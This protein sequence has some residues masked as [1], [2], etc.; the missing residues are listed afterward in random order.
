MRS[1][2]IPVR[3]VRRSI[4]SRL[5]C[6]EILI[7]ICLMCQIQTLFADIEYFILGPFKSGQIELNWDRLLLNKTQRALHLIHQGIAL[8]QTVISI[9]FHSLPSA[10]SIPAPI[11]VVVH[12]DQVQDPS[13][14]HVHQV[15]QI[16]WP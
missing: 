5:Y 11:Q 14:Q 12:T 15:I 8:I 9:S 7:E 6:Q 10:V 3:A 1:M 13:N 2:R 16:L 4:G